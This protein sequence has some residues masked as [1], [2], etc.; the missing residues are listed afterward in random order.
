MI[1][2]N[3]ISELIN[4]SGRLRMLSHRTGMLAVSISKIDTN[5]EWFTETFKSSMQAFE[6]GYLG[7]YEDVSHDSQF[8][9]E[10]EAMTH[11]PL[12]Q[13]GSTSIEE[14]VSQFLKR[15]HNINDTL[16][17][18]QKPSDHEL[19]TFLR[20]IACDLLEALNRLVH[21]FEEQL[22]K[23]TSHKKEG[24]SVL[25]KSIGD[26]LDEV[27]EINMTVKILSLN[28]SVEASKVGEAGKGFKVISQEMGS[29]SGQIRKFT[30]LIKRDI[31]SFIT[32]LE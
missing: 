30:E 21:F 32:K 15:L 9:S 12:F 19:Q 1:Q 5:D 10:L 17:L 18:S 14:V 4:Q 22:I 26:S 29:L 16:S 24:V 3:E 2:E 27:D 31:Q 13:N 6:G 8:K 23:L 11:T 7:L 28:A 25:T 20:F